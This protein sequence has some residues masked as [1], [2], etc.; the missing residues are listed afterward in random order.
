MKPE[1]ASR[2]IFQDPDLL[3]NMSLTP[4]SMIGDV[5]P[6]HQARVI[7]LDVDGTINHPGA[8]TTT[9]CPLCVK[10]LKQILDETRAEIVLSSTWRLTK[11]HRKALLRHLR[12]LGIDKG[13]VIGETRDL[14][15]EHKNRAEEISNWLRFPNLYSKTNS[16]KVVNWVSLDDMNLASME[17]DRKMKSHHIQIDPLLG[18]CKTQEIVGRVVGK[19]LWDPI[20]RQVSKDN[21]Y[22]SDKVLPLSRV[23]HNLNNRMLHKSFQIRVTQASNEDCGSS[24][25]PITCKPKIPSHND[26]SNE[27][28]K[29]LDPAIYIPDCTKEWS[30]D[31][32]SISSV[33]QKMG[34]HSTCSS[35]FF[36]KGNM[37]N[38]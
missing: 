11:N 1:W 27:N 37:V 19:L 8:S 38:C 22:C 9:I 6:Y 15:G 3:K 33:S 24:R 7:F 12:G 17:K 34:N 28:Q 13:L 25:L 5:S 35:G 14:S 4:D 20:F 36:F 18:L 16:C 23:P 26:G 29:S 10:A 2:I 30:V 21:G 31:L 32:D